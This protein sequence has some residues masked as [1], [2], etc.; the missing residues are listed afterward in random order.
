MKVLSRAE[1][2]VMLAILRLKEKAYCLEIL[3]QLENATGKKWTL[4]GVYAPL[5]RLEKNGLIDSFLGAHSP[6]K[7]GKSKRYYR[8]TKL[9][10]EALNEIKKVDNIMWNG[11]TEYIINEKK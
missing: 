3:E 7:G 11:L 5:N 1:E 6:E 2:L 9:G 4:G 8:V 10:I